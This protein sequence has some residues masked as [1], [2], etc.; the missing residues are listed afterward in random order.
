MLGHLKLPADLLVLKMKEFNIILGMDWLSEHYAF[1]DCR[2]KQVIFEIPGKGTCI[3]EGI[4]TQ[5]P[6][7]SST[8]LSCILKEVRAEGY[9]VSL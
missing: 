9:L 4:K 8:Q 5:T 2:G 3:F 6:E 7:S 1:I